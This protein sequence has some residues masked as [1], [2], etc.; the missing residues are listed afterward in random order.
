M[1]DRDRLL[2]LLITLAVAV[3]Y[4]FCRSE[5]PFPVTPVAPITPVAPVAP[6]PPV[7]PVEP[8]SPL[9]PGPCPQASAFFAPAP[10]PKRERG[11]EPSRLPTECVTRWWG[12]PYRTWFFRGGAYRSTHDH[13]EWT[14]TWSLDGLTLTI[15]ER[16]EPHGG[17]CRYVIQ[18]EPCCRRGA[19]TSG[20]SFLIEVEE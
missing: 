15:E 1:F 4:Y 5:A 20:S 3:G 14:G 17:T 6:S 7:E 18:M 11:V 12:V 19:F 16:L 9:C 13:L 2:V 8:I 10:L